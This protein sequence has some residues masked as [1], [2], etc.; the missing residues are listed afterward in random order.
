MNKKSC[1]L[2]LLAAAFL[3]ISGAVAALNPGAV[4]ITDNGNKYIMMRNFLQGNGL[5]IPHPAEELFPTGGFHFIRTSQ[6]IS[7]FYP[8][9]LSFFTAPFYMIFGE[10]GALVFPIAATLLL[11]FMVRRYWNIPP[12][13]LLL[14]T[15]LFFYS[16]LLWE[17]TPSVFMVT[18]AILLAGKKSYFYAGG[19]LGLSLLMREEAYFACAAMVAAMLL[20]GNWKAA[21][22]FGAG[23]LIPALV[24]WLYQ[25]GVHGHF[26]GN[27]GKYYYLNNNA[28]FSLLSQ[29]NRTFFNYYHHLFRFDG[30]ANP[31]VNVLIWSVLLPIAA[32]A[33]PGFKKWRKFKYAA[34]GIYLAAAAILA[35]GI[36]SH[37]NTVYAASALTG[38]LTATPI[39]LGFL[40]NWH[41]FLR[42]RKFRMLTVFLLL[43][44]LG[45]PPLMTASDIG[46]VWGARHF[47]V[48]LPLLFFMSF[49]GFR[50]MGILKWESGAVHASQSIPAAALAVSV[51]IQIF[52]LSALFRVSEDSY[53]IESRLLASTPE[54]IVT[55]VFYIPEQF[56]RLFFN[57]T[58]IQI[59]ERKDFKLL[60]KYLR[61]NHK[62]EE[63]LLVLSPGFRRIN[64][65]L[66]REML[67][68]F[69][70]ASP[71]E[72]LT[73]KGGFPELFAGVCR[74]K[75]NRKAFH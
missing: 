31:K 46:L 22:K 70:L 57:K 36:W 66:L 7:S 48:L 33:A 4:W 10:R 37:K 72:Q 38:L 43:Y 60:K 2:I 74:V 29:L 24:I 5:H 13:L 42:C 8:E 35:A 3:L 55:D 44:I 30:W 25:W 47:L 26:L 68:E 71:P 1:D 45:V 28:G 11:L 39:I 52:G 64:N 65:D 56:P 67:T 12:P 34:C 73:G 49:S 32:G 75:N 50:F 19:I 23:F 59:L 63:F 20:C 61:T 21:F 62:K 18:A 53:A 16:L 27:H 54:V 9:Y 15:P 14:S 41:G 58:V 40:V 6:G 51:F 69:P 17:M